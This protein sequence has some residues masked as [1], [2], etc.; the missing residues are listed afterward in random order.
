[1]ANVRIIEKDPLKEKLLKLFMEA[2]PF[3]R[4]GEPAD[5]ILLN[6]CEMASIPKLRNENAVAK[7][8]VMT[9]Q[10]EYSYPE[11]ALGMGADGFWYQK[12]DAE[13][14]N[15]C[16]SAVLAGHRCFPEHT[17]VVKLGAAASDSFTDREREVL[18]QLVMGKTDA[19]IAEVLRCSI[20]TVK[21]YIQKIREK[22]GLT[23][24][25]KLAVTVRSVGLVIPEE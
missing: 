11:T 2:S 23:T 12:P 4:L 17:P 5:V 25:V 19:Q 13:A 6:A 15:G 24:R 22:T 16:V 9:D 8:I 7:I 10:P 20:P 14:L 1:M 3:H 21:H 18:R